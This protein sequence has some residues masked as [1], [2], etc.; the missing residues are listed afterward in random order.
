[1]VGGGHS[2]DVGRRGRSSPA[3]QVCHRGSDHLTDFVDAARGRGV[4]QR[5]QVGQDTRVPND[6]AM[7]A[8][9]DEGHPNDTPA[10]IDI[11]CHAL[12]VPRQNSNW[13]PRTALPQVS[14]IRLWTP[15][16]AT[17]DLAGVVHGGGFADDEPR[18]RPEINNAAPIPTHGVLSTECPRRI[19]GD[20]AILADA[21]GTAYG[22]PQRAKIDELLL[23]SLAWR[24]VPLPVRGHSVAV[25]LERTSR[26]EPVSTPKLMNAHEEDVFV[27]D[28]LRPPVDYL[29]LASH[30]SN[31]WLNLLGSILPLIA[32]SPRS[33]P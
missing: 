10:R 21:V 1:M 30:W 5:Y 4:A 17:G 26:D 33:S 20:N 18:R 31:P 19:T 13:R 23:L 24:C 16:A 8:A 32:I 6:G 9:E 14:L 3:R 7:L 29:L 12:V 2:P 15:F 28:L 25:V 27:G 22:P 11:Q